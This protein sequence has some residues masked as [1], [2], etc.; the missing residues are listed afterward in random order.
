MG[1]GA[2]FSGQLGDALLVAKTHLNEYRSRGRRFRTVQPHQRAFKQPG[3]TRL[4]KRR[5]R[6][7]WKAF[8]AFGDHSGNEF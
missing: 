3:K 4:R 1:A 5:A 8:V 2:S 6:K 7:I